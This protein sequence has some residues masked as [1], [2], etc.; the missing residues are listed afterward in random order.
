M[1]AAFSIAY[2]GFIALTLPLFF[3]GALAVFVVTAPFDRRRVALHLFSCFWAT[4]YVWANP[5]WRCR[6]LG[7]E[8]LP[9]RAPAVIVANH[10]SLVDILVVYALFRPFKWVSKAENFRIPFIG[11]NMVLNGYVP[12]TRGAAESARRM[13]AR[14]HELLAAGAP[15]LLF[16]EGTRSPDGRLRPFKDGAFLIAGQA[17]VPLI[18]V[19]ISGTYETLPKRGIV[20]RNRMRAVVEVLDPI[21]PSRA[22]SVAEL[23]E[24]ARRAISE[25]L[26]RRAAPVA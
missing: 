13:V 12:L 9:W 6:V 17:G 20:L 23:R 24:A 26:E 10:A 19:A 8:K 16:P 1:Y 22:G 25:A 15:V 14:C 3:A 18:P 4:F 7:R 11:W 21:D 5:F 2:W